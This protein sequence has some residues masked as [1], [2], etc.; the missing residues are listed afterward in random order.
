MKL[1]WKLVIWDM[2]TKGQIKGQS[3][4]GKTLPHRKPE[5]ASRV[6]NVSKGMHGMQIFVQ[7]MQLSESQFVDNNLG[8]RTIQYHINTINRTPARHRHDPA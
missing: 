8:S 1:I 4:N 5:G 3:L 7:Y 6:F 2:N